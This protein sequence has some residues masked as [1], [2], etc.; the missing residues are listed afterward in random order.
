LHLEAT[1]R[2]L[3]RRP[4]NRVEV[5]EQV[6]TCGS[7]GAEASSRWSR[8][9]GVRARFPV[10]SLLDEGCHGGPTVIVVDFEDATVGASPS[11]FQAA[12]TVV[13]AE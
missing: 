4:A 3:Q 9:P 13:P 6:A 2:V 7:C 12:L 11:G 1:V 5:L 8:W 10:S